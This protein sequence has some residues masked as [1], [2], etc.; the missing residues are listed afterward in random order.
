LE[1]RE[2][3]LPEYFPTNWAVIPDICSTGTTLFELL[4]RC[5]LFVKR[6]AVDEGLDLDYPG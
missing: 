6:R 4:H 1:I 2:C 5:N 3:E